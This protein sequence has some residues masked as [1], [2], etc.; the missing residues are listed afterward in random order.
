MATK[1]SPSKTPEGS[2][3]PRSPEA[4]TPYIEL[5]FDDDNEVLYKP[6]GN[7]N[8]GLAK[9]DP[10]QQQQQAAETAVD[11]T[12]DLFDDQAVEEKRKNLGYTTRR[13]QS[14]NRPGRRAAA[15]PHKFTK[16]EAVLPFRF[17]PN[18]RPLTIA[19]LESCVAL[20][21]AAFAD[22][23]HRCT[24]EKFEYRL[25]TCPEMSLG[26]FCTVEPSEVKDMD[27]ELVTLPT[28]L[29]VETGRE[30]KSVLL[31]HIV[32]TRS[33]GL[34]VTDEAMDYPRD[35]R[36]RKGRNDTPLGHQANGDTICMHSVAVHPG[37][38]GCGL[39]NLIMKAYLQQQK[40]SSS[41]SRCALICQDYLIPYYERFHF[42]HYGPSEAT[43][44]GGGWHDMSVLLRDIMPPNRSSR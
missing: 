33:E 39:G 36:T 7:G 40:S 38:Q 18:I 23:E 3:P 9:P 10:A 6:Y 32:S 12:E 13:R 5:S 22:P 35:F 29:P 8:G 15:A 34:S 43:F 4:T 41:A 25:T 19:D 31:A 11:D 27:F 44:G 2:P 17:H 24:R 26:L 20:E 28:A 37:L 14:N 1:D 42:E 16:V 21:D 30:A